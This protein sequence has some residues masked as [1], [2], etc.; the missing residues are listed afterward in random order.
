MSD[1]IKS[2]VVQKNGNKPLSALLDNSFTVCS[3]IY[4]SFLPFSLLP[5]RV[6]LN[7][8]LRNPAAANFDLSLEL[9]LPISEANCQ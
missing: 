1:T 7:Y 4:S 8:Q 5:L 9:F 2:S 3:S 6:K